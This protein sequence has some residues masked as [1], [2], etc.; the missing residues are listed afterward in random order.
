MSR[1]L[2]WKR[3]CGILGAWPPRNARAPRVYCV[4][5]G[6]SIDCRLWRSSEIYGNVN[7]VWMNIR[8]IWFPTPRDSVLNL[9]QCIKIWYPVLTRHYTLTLQPE[10]L[11]PCPS[12]F[13]PNSNHCT[14]TWYPKPKSCKALIPKSVTLNPGPWTIDPG[15]WTLNSWPCILNPKPYIPKPWILN[16]EL[17]YRNPIS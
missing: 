4:F 13:A 16:L 3:T 12:P 7:V 11:S 17:K 8:Q 2:A 9:V 14:P 5:I 6:L 1:L 15:P 10:P